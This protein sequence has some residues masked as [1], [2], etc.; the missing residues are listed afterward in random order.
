MFIQRQ[1]IFPLGLGNNSN[2]NITTLPDMFFFL[3]TS[4]ITYTCF[5]GIILLAVLFYI[6]HNSEDLFI[7]SVFFFCHWNG[8]PASNI[9][10]PK[11]KK[12]NSKFKWN[13]IMQPCYSLV[14]VPRV[15]QLKLEEQHLTQSTNTSHYWMHPATR[16]LFPTWS[17]EPAKLIWECW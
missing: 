5:F 4:F 11:V 1:F 15:K 9:F 12:V 3:L 17:V 16:A 6:S 13:Y 14:F 8:Y 7:H 10:Q 2:A